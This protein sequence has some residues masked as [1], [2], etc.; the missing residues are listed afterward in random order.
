MMSAGERSSSSRPVILEIPDGF[1]FQ[2]W[3]EQRVELG[4]NRN[5]PT[6]R[7]M[8]EEWQQKVVRSR[9]NR[10]VCNQDEKKLL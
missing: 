5:Q 10:T 7:K 9:E 1:V 8:G 4:Q 3:S 2:L 6:E